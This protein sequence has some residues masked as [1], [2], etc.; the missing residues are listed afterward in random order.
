MSKQ[1][2]VQTKSRRVLLT[3]AT[4]FVGRHLEVALA[5]T[6]WEVRRATR[7]RRRAAE[8][9][10]AY[11]DV[12]DASSIEPALEGCDA[13]I[14]LIHSIDNTSDYPEREAR[15]AEAFRDAAERAGVQRIIYLG[16]VAPA[17]RPS[18]HLASR[19]HTGEILRAG[20][21]ST[22]ELRCSMIIGAGGKLLDDGARPRSSAS[23]DA[24]AAMAALL[25]LARVD[26]GC[27]DRDRPC[28]RLP[29]RR[30][31]LV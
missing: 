10:W 2:S 19:L 13:A 28:A 20:R 3:G 15:S 7:D 9:G 26:R 18:R 24:A 30:E 4:G 25:V 17:T 29:A 27:G 31:R 14:Y 16:G 1:S 8:P 22:I 12:E 6:N 5:E 23:S 11:L 21:V